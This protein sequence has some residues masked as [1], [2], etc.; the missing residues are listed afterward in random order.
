MEQRVQY[1]V[2]FLDW[3]LCRHI[4]FITKRQISYLLHLLAYQL[5]GHKLG[6]SFFLL[7]FLSSGSFKCVN[8]HILKCQINICEIVS[9]LARLNF[10]QSFKKKTEKTTVVC[11][12]II[13][14][15]LVGKW[16]QFG[17]TYW[18]YLEPWISRGWYQ[19][20][21]LH[22]VKTQKTTMDLFNVFRASNLK[23]VFKFCFLL[24]VVSHKFMLILS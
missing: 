10:L 17:R 8:F 24:E 12:D 5:T 3:I 2:T 6:T 16:Q 19:P 20:T 4:E 13:P 1:N 21:S 14:S 23:K 15:K 22:R 9:S 7:S 18:L 11:R